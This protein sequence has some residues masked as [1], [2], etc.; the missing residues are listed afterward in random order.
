MEASYD[1]DADAAYVTIRARR[2]SGRTEVAGDGTVLDREDETGEITGYELLSVSHRGLDAF[3]A[4][5]PAARQLVA[6]A[7]DAARARGSYIRIAER[8]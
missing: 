3:Q 6:R 4:V 2:G 1:P 8:E 5:P 7:M